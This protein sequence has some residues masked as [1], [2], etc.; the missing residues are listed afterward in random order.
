MTYDIKL[1]SSA[2]YNIQYRRNLAANNMT[3]DL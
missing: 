2:Y 3:Y 1:H